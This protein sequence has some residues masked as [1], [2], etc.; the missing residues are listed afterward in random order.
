[1]QQPHGG[2][3]VA[4][5]KEIGC[6]VREVIDLSSNINFVKPNIEL[7]FNSLNISPYPNY[8]KLESAIAKLYDIEK[9]QLELFNG[10]TTA[11]YTLFRELGLK[12]CVLYAP[13]Y[14]EY[15]RSAKVNGYTIHYI[16][17][18]EN[19]YESVPKNALVVFVNPSTPDGNYYDM[20]R[21]MHHWREQECTVLVDESFL[22]FTP[23]SSVTK[24]LK[25]YDK[26]YVLKSMT[27]FYASAGIR[28]GVLLSCEKNIQAIKVKEPLWKLSEFDSHYL[29]S[30]LKDKTFKERSKKK[31]QENKEFLITLFQQ[32]KYT[33]QIYPSSANF[34]LIKLQD[35]DATSL[36]KALSKFKILIRNCANFYPLNGSYA[37]IAVKSRKDLNILKEALLSLEKKSV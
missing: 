32:F 26:L 30:A 27:K 3:I 12:E 7:D 9:T 8:D 17:R 11:I 35:I 25:E 14:G 31:N 5:A 15:E 22:D 10:A 34:I 23:Y 16:N 4:F 33:K 21:L 19:L 1:M 2:N 18:F 13:C 36:Q 37:R 20:D 6:E 24:Y 29:Q 28:I